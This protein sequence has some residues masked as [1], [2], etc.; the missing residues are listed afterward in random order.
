MKSS[1]KEQKK[2]GTKRNKLGW[3]GQHR[4]VRC[5]S[6]CTVCSRVQ[7]GT[8]GYNSSDGPRRALDNPM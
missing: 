6:G 3:I 4:T 2:V 7:L 8:L 1:Q 5:S